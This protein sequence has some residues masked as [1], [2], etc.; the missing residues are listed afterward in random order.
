MSISSSISVRAAESGLEAA[1]Q[2]LLEGQ[3]P[4]L[5]RLVDPSKEG[6]RTEAEVEA[7]LLALATA[8]ISHHQDVVDYV[9]KMEEKGREWRFELE[10][11]SS[12]TQ[13]L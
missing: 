5:G 2:E 4:Y 8:A 11:L 7:G 12:F 6:R 13:L 10:E 9:I 3:S 1:S